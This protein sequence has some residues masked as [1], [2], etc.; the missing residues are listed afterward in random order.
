[1]PCLGHLFVYDIALLL[2]VAHIP[3][4]HLLE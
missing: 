4:L 2:F 3:S 1:L